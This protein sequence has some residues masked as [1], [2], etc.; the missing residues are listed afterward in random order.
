MSPEFPLV[1]CTA[2]RLGPTS[3]LYRNGGIR[4][5]DISQDRRL[6][7]SSMLSGNASNTNTARKPPVAS[8]DSLTTDLY[9]G[10]LHA[11][12]CACFV[13]Y[14]TMLHNLRTS[15]SASDVT[16]PCPVHTVCTSQPLPKNRL[17][18]TH[19][20]ISDLRWHEPLALLLRTHTCYQPRPTRRYYCMPYSYAM[21]VR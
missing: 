11:H 15:D 8:A 14:A 12:I 2:N 19:T 16:W 5:L 17:T 10:H 4:L 13:R 18:Y 9:A 20:L 6:I 7:G 3:I 21:R 1:C